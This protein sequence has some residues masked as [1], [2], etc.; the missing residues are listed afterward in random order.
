MNYEL[1][2]YELCKKKKKK[3]VSIIHFY[4]GF[5]YKFA[6]S[7][8][9]KTKRTSLQIECQQHHSNMAAFSGK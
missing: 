3:K 7:T 1:E 4:A 6:D 5:E 9:E 8:E 2:V